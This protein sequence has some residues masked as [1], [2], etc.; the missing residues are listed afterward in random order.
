[1]KKILYILVISSV[2]MFGCKRSQID[3]PVNP[4]QPEES[5][6]EF[7][8]SKSDETETTSKFEQ[9]DQFGIYMIETAKA[10]DFKEFKAKNYGYELGATK[11]SP[12]N[13]AEILK[14]RSID[15][16][17]NFYSY[18]PRAKAG[19]YI[20]M[21]ALPDGAPADTAIMYKIPLDQSA[22][23]F[24]EFDLLRCENSGIGGAGLSMSGEP[25]TLK[26]KHVLSKIRFN[27]YM[28]KQKDVVAPSGKAM[29]NSVRIIS[30][31][32][33]DQGVMSLRNGSLTKPKLDNNIVWSWN[34]N[35]QFDILANDVVDPTMRGFEF[36]INTFVPT[37]K[38]TWYEF[39]VSYENDRQELIT[40]VCRYVVPA[41]GSVKF[42]SGKKV[43]YNTEINI[44]NE[45]IEL[46]AGI[47]D[48]EE[49]NF[50]I[51]PIG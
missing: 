21:A 42:L 48:W 50:V 11:W 3:V 44:S 26:Y 35:E 45:Q 43:V 6:I 13:V 5:L 34:G 7:G 1:M 22:Q 51:K 41:D 40:F 8:G 32:I 31:D 30:K 4:E 16:A 19:S 25:V 36:M 38:N 10:A 24:K 17:C 49:E 9:G 23:S 39:D 47:V 29:L 46:E 18:S 27:I 14:W 37:D 12:I 28:T 33:A 20:Q 2:M 15:P